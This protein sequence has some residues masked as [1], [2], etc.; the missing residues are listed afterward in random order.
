M[1]EPAVPAAA[2]CASGNLMSG[3]VGPDL[4]KTQAVR[5]NHTTYFEPQNPRQDVRVVPRSVK[6]RGAR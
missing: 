2:K 1:L 4:S 3:Y 5:M 6:E